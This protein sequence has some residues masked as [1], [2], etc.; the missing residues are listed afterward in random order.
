MIDNLMIAGSP[1]SINGFIDSL[2]ISLPYFYLYVIGIMIIISILAYRSKQLTLSGSMAAFLLG[3]VVTFAFGTGGL[4]VYLFF[5][6]LAGV[7]SKLNKNNEIY[8]EAEEIQEK[9]SIRD[10]VQVLSN[11]GPVLIFSLLYIIQPHPLLLIM[12]GGSICEAVCDTSAGEVG[13]FFRGR[14][15]S[16]ITGRPQKSGLSGGVSFEGTLGGFIASLIIAMIW[17]SCFF[18][19]SFSTITYMFV[20]A[21]AGFAGCLVDS[22]MGASVQAHYYDKKNEC[23][24]EREEIDGNKLELVRG[25]RF[26][27]NDRVNLISN[28]FSVIFA[29]LLGLLIL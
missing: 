23:V 12:F 29:L 3:S 16:I 9:G 21:F 27:N 18:Y 19:P 14:T 11:A 15:V 20:A 5:V 17:Y 8:K 13:M 4:L 7:L 26:F 22:I 24:T 6:I 25:I 1:N 2:I 28:I 10:W